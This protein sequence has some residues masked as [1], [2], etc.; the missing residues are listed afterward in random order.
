QLARPI[1][2]AELDTQALVDARQRV[3]MF[4]PLAR[5]PAVKRDLAIVVDDTVL[6]ADI[7]GAVR[8]LNTPHLR[9]L[10]FFDEFRGKQIPAGKKSLAF[11]MVFRDEER[12]LVSS[13]VDEQV[14]KIIEALKAT[15]GAEIRA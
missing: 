4:K 11:A 12:T 7:E 13:E 6:W 2:L 15:C 1:A 3:S 8:A 5:F 9:G 10:E 14:S